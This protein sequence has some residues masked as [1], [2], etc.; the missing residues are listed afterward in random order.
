MRKKKQNP[1]KCNENC[2]ECRNRFNCKKRP[3]IGYERLAFGSTADAFRLLMAD[4]FENILVENLD[5]FNVAEI[6][7]PKDGAM[8]IKFFDRIKA[9]EHLGEIPEPENKTVAFYDVLSDCAKSL[10]SGNDES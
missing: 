9:L 10:R 2:F 6:K 8:E 4:N 3:L 7:K 5:L 1:E